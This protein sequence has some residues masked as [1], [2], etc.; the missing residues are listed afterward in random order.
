MKGDSMADSVV[1]ILVRT[2]GEDHWVLMERRGDGGAYP[3]AWLLPSG[4]QEPDESLDE[5]LHREMAEELGCIPRLYGDIGT[6]DEILY[7]LGE[8]QP[9]HRLRPRLVLLWDGEVPAAVLDNGHELAWH[10]LDDALTSPVEVTVRMA[11]LAQR[12]LTAVHTGCVSRM[13]AMETKYLHDLM[14]LEDDII[15]REA[16]L[17]ALAQRLGDEGG[18]RHGDG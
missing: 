17:A 9:K 1:F 15:R 6:G 14:V 8:H 18:R 2:D 11:T 12:M 16:D 3:N 5:T 13:R 10:R 7:C 4:K